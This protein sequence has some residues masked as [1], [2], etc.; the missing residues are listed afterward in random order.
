[1]DPDPA[2]HFIGS[3]LGTNCL[4]M[5]SADDTSWQR[6]FNSA[7]TQKSEMRITLAER[8]VFYHVYYRAVKM[9]VL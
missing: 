7:K 5:L 4:Q 1:M 3:D 2:R 6:V 9:L 8:T